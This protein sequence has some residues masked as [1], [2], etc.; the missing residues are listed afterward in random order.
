MSDVIREM[1]VVNIYVV[2]IQVRERKSDYKEKV[3]TILFIFECN[4]GKARV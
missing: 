1:E 3:N 2:L 4:F